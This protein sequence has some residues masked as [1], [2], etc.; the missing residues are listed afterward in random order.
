[1]GWATFWVTCLQTHL[2]TLLGGKVKG[3]PQKLSREKASRAMDQAS[4][5]QDPFFC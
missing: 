5:R 3:L 2:V 4:I 1:M